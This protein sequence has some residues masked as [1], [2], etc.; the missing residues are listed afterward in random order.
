[1]VSEKIA[2]EGY[3][4]YRQAVGNLPRWDEL[5]EEEQAKW[6]EASTY[7]MSRYV[8]E[9]VTANEKLETA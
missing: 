7:P 6:L 9:A 8:G 5:T 3:Q 2:K 1:M 4:R